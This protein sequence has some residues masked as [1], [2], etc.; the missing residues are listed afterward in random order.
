MVDDTR[1]NGR[2]VDHPW[3]GVTDRKRL[4][5]TM[6]PRLVNETVVKI[7]QSVLKPSFVN[8]DIRPVAL[9]LY[10][11]PPCLKQV[12]NRNDFVVRWLPMMTPPPTVR[13]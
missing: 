6:S 2:L 1:L 8:H 3:L 4:I 12:F 13:E 9:A 7:K 10:K 5:R 11:S